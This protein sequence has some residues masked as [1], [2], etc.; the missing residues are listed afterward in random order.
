MPTQTRWGAPFPLL[1][2][3]TPPRGAPGRGLGQAGEPFTLD[4]RSAE[5]VL[6]SFAIIEAHIET[7]RLF[8]GVWPELAQ[9]SGLQTDLLFYKDQLNK[10][11][12]RYEQVRMT[13]ALAYLD[14]EPRAINVDDFE[15][16]KVLDDTSASLSFKALGLV[17]E[18]KGVSKDDI[19]AKP[20]YASTIA[21]QYAGGGALSAAEIAGLAALGVVSL[22]GLGLLVF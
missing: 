12:A 18:A 19:R 17:P 20:L 8:M 5:S 16:L 15:M 11:R 14:G 7:V 4:R 9:S 3:A 6:N 10:L 13:A 2:P 22:V 21:A 1:R